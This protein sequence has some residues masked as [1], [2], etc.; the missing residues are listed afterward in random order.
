MN[1]TTNDEV[2]L[3]PTPTPLLVDEETPPQPTTTTTTT[4]TVDEKDVSTSFSKDSDE[5]VGA[6]QQEHAGD[7]SSS[8]GHGL[9]RRYS[10]KKTEQAVDFDSAEMRQRRRRSTLLFQNP[11]TM[12][13]MLSNELSV[14]GSTAGFPKRRSSQFSHRPSRTL[15][16]TDSIRLATSQKYAMRAVYAVLVCV[17]ADAIN[18]QCTAPN[19]PLMVTIGGH[20]DS[21]PNTT[22]FDFSSAQ[23]MIYTAANSGAFISNLAAGWLSDRYGRR[24]IMLIDLAG[25]VVFTIGKYFASDSY[26]FFC[27]M[28]FAN[29]LFASTGSVAVGYMADIFVNDRAKADA[30][31][32][33]VI[34]IAVIGRALGG[35]LT[36][37]FPDHLFQPL[38]P[39][40][41]ITFLG[42]LVAYYLVLEPKGVRKALMGGETDDCE[43]TD[44]DADLPKT[45]DYKALFNIIFGALVDNGGSYGIIRKYLSS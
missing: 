36:V 12:A 29:G 5:E 9:R 39:A 37:M 22:P 21:F 45:M 18:L 32:N 33:H 26:W 42:V 8:N 25:S 10:S 3:P 31:M 28:T 4:T 41:V 15:V 6:E 16:M 40:T 20:P 27:G 23:Y 17:F 24:R 19:Y 14:A 34:A 35:L 44:K 43:K 7:P 2:V 1:T 11:T 38:I 30:Y 13:M